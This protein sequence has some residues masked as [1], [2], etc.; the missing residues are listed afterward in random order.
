MEGLGNLTEGVALSVKILLKVMTV[1]ARPGLDHQII[2]MELDIPEPLKV[3]YHAPVL[4]HGR[5]KNP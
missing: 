5:P 3:D 2:L 1:Y 4:G